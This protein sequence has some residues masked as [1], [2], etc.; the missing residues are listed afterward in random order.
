MHLTENDILDIIRR[1]VPAAN[2][3]FFDVDVPF[4][5][6]DI[7]SLDALSIVTAFEEEYHITIPDEDM[8][9]LDSVT[10]L[11]TYANTRSGVAA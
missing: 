2:L 9:D 1:T 4:H 7:D 8:Q 3:D 11:V 5:Q 6:Q 10:A